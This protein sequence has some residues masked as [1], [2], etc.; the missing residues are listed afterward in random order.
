MS[1]VT[2]DQEH[3]DGDAVLGVHGM[4]RKM[5]WHLDASATRTSGCLLEVWSEVC[6]WPQPSNF[7]HRDHHWADVA[8]ESRCL[9]SSITSVHQVVWTG[10]LRSPVLGRL[11][12]ALGCCGTL[13]TYPV[14]LTE[15]RLNSKPSHKLFVLHENWSIWSQ[16]WGGISGWANAAW[17]WLQS[18]GTVPINTSHVELWQWGVMLARDGWASPLRSLRFKCHLT[19]LYV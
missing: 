13:I 17:R 14:A 1:T 5:Q 11:L 6:L 7:H 8:S 19:V 12:A 15:A 16:W 9:V 10:S 4:L 2:R 18:E 3:Q